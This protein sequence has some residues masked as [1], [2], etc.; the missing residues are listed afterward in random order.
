MLQL[1]ERKILARELTGWD[2]MRRIE[3]GYDIALLPVG[4]ME[5]HGPQ[6]PLATDT[7]IAEAVCRLAA[8]EMKG[9]VFVTIS[10]TWPG[11]TKYSFPTISMSMDMETG[12]TRM[13]CDELAR[14]GLK[15]IHIIQFHGPGIA[16]MR[17]AREFFEEKGVPLVFYGLLRMPHSGKKECRDSGIAW[18][19]SLCAA[20]IELLG[21]NATIDPKAWHENVSLKPRLGQNATKKILETGGLVGILGTNDLQHGT[22]RDRVDLNIGMEILQ[23]FAKNIASSA[24]AMAELRDAWKNIDLPT[25]WPGTITQEQFQ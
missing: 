21:Y 4:T 5:M 16:L 17:L 23:R 9:T 10:Y 2:L 6:L 19:A 13:I 22:F 24:D 7:Y 1:S 18:E 8:I 3:N 14:I 12:Y 11:I 25:S 20:A 15:R